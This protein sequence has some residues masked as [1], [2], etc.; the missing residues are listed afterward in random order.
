MAGAS[1]KT[2]ST[3]GRTGDRDLDSHLRALEERVLSRAQTISLNG[4]ATAIKGF[5]DSDTVQWIVDA[6][7]F[8]TARMKG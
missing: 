3:G 2:S 8:L 6:N 1:N 5:K 7:G 4:A